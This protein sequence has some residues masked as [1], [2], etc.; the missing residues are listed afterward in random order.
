MELAAKVRLS[1]NDGSPEAQADAS[2]EHLPEEQRSAAKTNVGVYLNDFISIV[3]GGPRE[4]RQMLRHLFHQINWVFHL[5][6]EAD[7]NSKYPISLKK[8]GQGDGAWSTWKTFL[9][10]DLDTISHLLHLPPR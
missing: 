3:Q 9:E 6:K 5:N 1:G 10:W 7:T 4:R 2:W 8:L